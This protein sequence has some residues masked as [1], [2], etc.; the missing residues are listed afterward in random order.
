MSADKTHRALVVDDEKVIRRLVAKAL[1]DEGVQ[2]DLAADGDEAAQLL[3]AHQYDL[4]VTDL[5][6]PN[7]HGHSLVRDVLLLSP[8]PIIIVHTSV[9]EPKIAR[10]LLSRGIDD[11]IYKP[12]DAL[13]VAAKAKTLLERRAASSPQSVSTSASSIAARLGSSSAGADLKVDAARLTERLNEISSVLPISNAALDVY[14]MTRD[15]DWEISQIAAAIQRDASLSAEVLRLANSSFYNTTGHG[16]VKLDQAVM[17]IGQTRIGEMAMALNALALVTPS[18]L[19]WMNLDLAWRRSMA[20]SVAVETL[21]DLGGHS[22][23]EEGL[24]LS[25]TLYPLG[26]VVL[27]ALFPDLYKRLVSQCSRGGESLRQLEKTALPVSHSAALAQL[28]AVWRI[29]TELCL[30]LTYAAGEFSA[31][32]RTVDPLRSKAELLK[33]AI[34]VGHIAVGEWEPWD[35]VELPPA[36][37]LER[38]KTPIVDD[39]LSRI[40]VDIAKLANF[41]PG[42]AV[43]SNPV[44]AP[45]PSRNVAYCNLASAASDLLAELLPSLGYRLQHVR[46]EELRD[47]EAPAI[48]NGIDS[49]ATRFAAH[50]GRNPA[51]VVTTPERAAAFGK[52]AATI[53]V[54]CSFASLRSALAGTVGEAVAPPARQGAVL[55]QLAAGAT[56][57]LT[58]AHS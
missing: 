42:R 25:A 32:A 44:G 43:S 46:I 13:L 1:A 14:H 34:L 45:Q 56:D 3:A 22:A 49:P 10:D 30:P 50:Y 19:P 26:R 5:K 36:T 39:L 33:L 54:P 20:A 23:V 15:C 53:S 2:C 16:V 31:I 41:H 47:L 38:L 6:M 18:V 35:T 52:F 58:A 57:A 28:L 55:S 21:I 8:R 4:L 9:M 40:R 48:I 24:P 11:I 27:G 37:V 12:S 7:R 51:I 17:S 29:P